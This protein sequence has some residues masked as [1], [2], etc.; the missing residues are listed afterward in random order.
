M[1][2]R[3]GYGQPVIK[4]YCHVDPKPAT[5]NVVPYEGQLENLNLDA[6]CDN[7]ECT[8]IIAGELI[9]Y[10]PVDKVF[11]VLSHVAM[12]LRHAGRITVGGTDSRMVGLGIVNGGLDPAEVNR[13]LYA[14]GHKSILPMNDMALLLSKVGLIVLSREMNGCNYLITAERP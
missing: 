11:A 2:L 5:E 10:I 7:N 3:I 9:N 8:E 12:K 6:V 1:K 13:V 14:E 4:G